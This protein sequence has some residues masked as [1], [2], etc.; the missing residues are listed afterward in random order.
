MY[1]AVI[2]VLNKLLCPPLFYYLIHKFPILL[3]ILF[4]DLV[5][6]ESYLH[7]IL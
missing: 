3:G 7:Y 1:H 4:I 2:N 5:T 6:Q